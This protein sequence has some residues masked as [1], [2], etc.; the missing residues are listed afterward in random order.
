[1][2]AENENK[3][4]EQKRR[5][6]SEDNS[7]IFKVNEANT[8][9]SIAGS[10]SWPHMFKLN[11]DCFELLFDLFSLKDLLAFRLT[12]K[13]M[14][15]VVDY[16]LKLNYPKL[17]WLELDYMNFQRFLRSDLYYFDGVKHLDLCV[18]ELLT[19][20]KLKNLQLILDRFESIRLSCKIEGDFYE[21]FLKYCDRLKYL[22]IKASSSNQ[23]VGNGNQWLLRDYP[24]LEHF[25]CGAFERDYPFDTSNIWNNVLKFLE[26]HPKIQIFSTDLAKCTTSKM[27]Q[28]RIIT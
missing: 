4:C 21:K 7:E 17:L 28:I 18:D 5:K 19:D 22:S 9:V 20:S 15:Q 25:G 12:C 14:K 2:S 13:R 26:R 1:M 6:T 27:L 8:N 11:V 24:N 23:L 10:S 3:N 16:Y